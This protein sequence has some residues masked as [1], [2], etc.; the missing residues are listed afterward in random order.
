MAN[1]TPTILSPTLATTGPSSRTR[2]LRAPKRA[3]RIAWAIP[4][5]P[6]LRRNTSFAV[7]PLLTRAE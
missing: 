4:Q 5:K 6:K 1:K 7:E 2:S 3:Q